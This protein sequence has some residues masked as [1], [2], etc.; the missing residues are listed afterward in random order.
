MKKSRLYTAMSVLLILVLFSQLSLKANEQPKVEAQGAV[1]IEKETGR[2]LWEK[3]AHKPLAMASTTKIMTAILALELGNMDDTVT[4]SKRAAAAPKVKMYLQVNEE[5]K[6][7]SLLYALMM[8]SANDAAV[9]VAEHIGGTVE[10]FCFMMTQKARELGA[11]NTVFETPSGLDT[12]NHRSTAYD[13]AQIARYAVSNQQ[14][15]DITNTRSISVA[16]NKTTYNLVNKNRLL[17]E[18]EGANGIKTGFTGKA[19]Y[20]FVGSAKRGDVHL[21][22]VALTSGWGAK[23]KEQKWVDTKRILNYGFENYAIEEVIMQGEQVG[24]VDIIKSKTT[25]VGLY[26]DKSVVLPLT[27]QELESLEI[28]PIYP[29][30]IEAPISANVVIGKADIV[31]NGE[32]LETVDILTYNKAD[33]HDFWTSL[34]KVLKQ[35]IN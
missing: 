15:M 3:N 19:G 31:V 17:N 33:R 23:G 13:M 4:I 2:V 34:E 32:V 6:L 16:S 18:Y 35:L 26:F 11:Y 8:Q 29:L 7:K 12:E 27:T 1:L 24:V 14:F 9:A 20:C 25:E 5:I 28:L 22:S 30:S 21:L 10:H